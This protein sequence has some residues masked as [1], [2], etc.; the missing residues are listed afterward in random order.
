MT[1]GIAPEF[2]VLIVFLVNGAVFL[3]YAADK[4][5]AATGQWRISE[6]VLLFSA[7]FGPFGAFFAMHLFRHKTQKMKF[8]I[9]PL[10][11][12]LQILAALWFFTGL[13]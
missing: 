13:S 6:A 4:T 1:A 8:L 2:P 11:C 7:L 3:I 5:R 9:V 12:F 10:F